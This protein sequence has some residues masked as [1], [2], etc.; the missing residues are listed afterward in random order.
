V[1]DVERR[2]VQG[3]DAVRRQQEVVRLHPA[4][5]RVA[6]RELPLLPDHLHLEGGLVV[7][8]ERDR[9]RA[10]A[11]AGAVLE[12]LV[13][14]EAG[15]EEHHRR[16]DHDPDQLD[17]GVLSD[18]R[19]VKDRCVAPDVELDEPVAEE[20]DHEA[21]DRGDE[22]RHH[23]VAEGLSLP[24]HAAVARRDER[25]DVDRDERRRDRAQDEPRDDD[26]QAVVRRAAGAGGRGSR[27]ACHQALTLM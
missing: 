26:P 24:L 13:C 18:R 1:D 19:A 3:D 15:E 21:E 27:L 16:G 4:E 10:L 7:G 17:A 8:W 14:P 6:I 5:R 25:P 9:V 22:G 12:E 23:L 11:T 20:D 2:D